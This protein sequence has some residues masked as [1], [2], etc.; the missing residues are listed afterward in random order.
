MPGQRRLGMDH[1]YYD[2]SPLTK[3]GTLRWPA[4]ARVALCVIVNLE[5]LEWSPPQG[6]YQSPTIAGGRGPRP[7]PNYLRFSHREYGHR[8]GVFRVLEVLEKHGIPP[9]VAMDALTAEN[10]PYLVR[11][12][13]DRGCEIIGHG[14]SASRTITSAMLE[15]EERQYIQTSLDA[16]KRATGNS[17]AGWL[18]PEYGES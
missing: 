11:Y 9:T 14:I 5:H 13:M 7:F 16:L 18:G 8:V 4:N 3:R 2:W 6:S 15:Q 12:C 17:P 1:E 10:Y